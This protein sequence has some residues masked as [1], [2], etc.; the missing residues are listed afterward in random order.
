MS[1]HGLD[2]VGDLLS[3]D[4]VPLSEVAD[5]FATPCYVYSARRI[6]ENV[7]R[8]RS[9]LAGLPGQVCY[10]VKANS[11]LAVLRL[12]SRE[13]L[14]AEV[15]S[16]GELVRAVRAGFPPNEIL[17]SG[18]GKREDELVMALATGVRAMIV[19]SL[20]E[21][22]LIDHLA[23]SK[24]KRAHVV[25]RVH[26]S[27]DLHTHPYLATAAEGTKF[28]MDPE[29]LPPALEFLTTTRALDL[30]GFH[31]HLGSQIREVGPYL[32]A[33]DRLT[34]CIG[35]ARTRGL[36]PRF[37]DLGGG[38]AIPYADGETAFPLD[39]LA[40]ALHGYDF[41][42]LQLLFEPGRA[43][44]ADA[45]VLLTR[46]LF[47]K[48]VHGQTFVVVDAGM[49]DLIRPILYGGWHRVESVMR[50]DGPVELVNVVGPIC[51][52]AD[53]L[54]QRI[55]LPTV[56]RG[57]LLA[58]RDVGAYGFTMSSQYN[59]RPRAAE[60]LI[61]DGKPYLVRSRETLADLWQGEAVP[62]CL[63]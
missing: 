3:M 42:G 10:A 34:S 15:V 16:G 48:R 40:Q 59:S 11:N 8:F 25:L 2:Y 51:E 53:F 55:P 33:L 14:G 41:Q 12:L 1:P 19:E 30:A 32:A 56:V 44:V 31:V 20:E 23:Q 9:S 52:N 13:G 5:Q 60:V 17:F 39:Q 7:E 50:W 37:L 4:G 61:V 35:E 54:A 43:L 49:N 21:L 24:R 38:F 26:P 22:E 47:R 63:A 36:S 6:R 18:V 29:A 27:L 46:V 28:G 62:E 58:I 57:E 45:G